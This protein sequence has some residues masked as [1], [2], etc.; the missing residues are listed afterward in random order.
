MKQITA[1][2]TIGLLSWSVFA[3]EPPSTFLSKKL[4]APVAGPTRM[5]VGQ[6]V[7]EGLSQFG[8]GKP[9]G[10]WKKSGKSWVHTLKYR[11]KVSMKKQ[12][13]VQKFDEEGSEAILTE[14]TYEGKKL[15]PD[16]SVRFV[17]GAAEKLGLMTT[18][19][20]YTPSPDEVAARKQMLE[21]QR[22]LQEQIEKQTKQIEKSNEGK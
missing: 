19:N 12:E 4:T 22:Q 7:G 3:E 1:L 17:L 20:T 16:L 21:Q 5:T 14:T 15:T 18:N 2:V 6:Y 9:E 13:L 11:D 8:S 10:S